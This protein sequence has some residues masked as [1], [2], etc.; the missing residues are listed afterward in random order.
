MSTIKTL[1]QLN[2]Q[3]GECPRWN[4]QERSWYWVDILGKA[5]YRYNTLNQQLSSR[6]FDFNPACFA[7]TKTNQIILTASSGLFL[8]ENFSAA[9]QF[10]IDPESDQPTQ[11]FNDGVPTPDGNLLAGT[12]GDATTAT[13]NLYYFDI[14]QA[15]ISHQTVMKGF[16]IINGQAFSPDGKWLYI[17]DTPKQKILKHPY[18]S[19]TKKLGKA[20]L[21]F[22][23]T[24]EDE[25][26][27]GAAI[28]AE[29]NYW[30][31]MYG[32]GKICVISPEGNKIDEI[33]LPISQPTMVAF[34][35]ENLKQLIITSA[36]QDLN[37]E[38]LEK[39]PLA[40]SVLVLDISKK[41]AL[42]FRLNTYKPSTN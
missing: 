6:I 12:I 21:F 37:Q 33:Y 3:L 29:G 10:I 1:A 38:R 8:L 4:E 18:N 16:I 27:D 20:Q 39:E 30:I 13:G 22:K 32:A 31:A 26:P 2:M 19:G 34:G 42:P 25:Y 15:S 35:G 11:R 5:L 41:G 28:D 7:F 23:F 24:Q 36:A 17:T 9:V 40:G 14:G